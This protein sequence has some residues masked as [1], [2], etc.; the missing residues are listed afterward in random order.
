V[1]LGPIGGFHRAAQAGLDARMRSHQPATRPQGK[2]EAHTLKLL[3]D[4]PSSNGLSSFSTGSIDFC[5][6]SA[7]APW[8]RLRLV[9]GVSGQAT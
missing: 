1:Q 9:P 8:R 3:V 2:P 5:L 7:C 4:P 6:S